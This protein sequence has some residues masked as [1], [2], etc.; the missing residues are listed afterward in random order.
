MGRCG[1]SGEKRNEGQYFSE[2][3]KNFMVV[4]VFK[5]RPVILLAKV[6]LREVR[7]W[8]VEEVNCWEVECSEYAVKEIS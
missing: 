6:I 2:V 1:G 7:R 8:K 4:Q 3:I 5:Q